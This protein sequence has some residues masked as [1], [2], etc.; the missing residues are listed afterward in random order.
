MRRD[1]YVVAELSGK[2]FRRRFGVSFTLELRDELRRLLLR[3]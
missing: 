2:P 1:F 3:R